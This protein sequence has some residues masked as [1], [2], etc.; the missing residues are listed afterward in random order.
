MNRLRLSAVYVGILLAGLLLF[1]AAAVVAIDRAQR[2]TLD[3]RLQTGARAVSQFVDIHEGHVDLD[4]DD[5]AQIAEVV[6]ADANA[7]V[8][9]QNGTLA[10]ATTTRL[11]PELRTPNAWQGGFIDSGRSEARLRAF[12]LPVLQHGTHAGTIVVW[13]GSRWIDEADRN[14]AIALGAGALLI[15]VLALVAGNVVTRRALE[16]AFARQRRF[17]ADASHELRAPLAVIRAE[18]DL[19]LRKERESLQY[20]SALATIASEADHMERL[21]GDLLSAARAEGG[22]LSREPIDVSSILPRVAER[23]AP[24]A[25]AKDATIRVHTARGAVILADAPALERALLAIGHNAVRYAPAGG[26]VTLTAQRSDAAVE[27]AVQDSGA[28]FSPDALAHALERFWRE[29]GARADGGTGLGL[30]IARSIVEAHKGSIALANA[31]DG[32]ALVRMNFPAA[33]R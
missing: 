26:T 31:P 30:A 13:A 8:L 32:G 33:A 22:A 27:I 17:T 14:F 3:A 28:G 29:P 5:R 2:A 11:L 1:A 20:Q 21:I 9:S 12:V 19:A 25:A 24:A 10:F 6:G 7:A 4:A 18:A 23:L 16:D 15:A